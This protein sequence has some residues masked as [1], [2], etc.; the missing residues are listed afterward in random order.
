MNVLNQFGDLNHRTT[1]PDDPAPDRLRDGTHKPQGW[2]L[3]AGGHYRHRTH[4]RPRPTADDYS[5]PRQLAEM[6]AAWDCAEF[7]RRW[8]AQTTADFAAKREAEKVEQERQRQEASAQAAAAK[9]AQL[10]EP[11]RRAFLASGG[12]A[13]MWEE[14]RDAIAADILREQAVRAGTT[15]P[16]PSFDRTA[17]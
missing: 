8:R 2:H 1:A 14:Q 9:R 6:Q 16:A 10:L 13:E 17:F 4:E 5:N 3:G 7:G 12:T 15:A 11:A